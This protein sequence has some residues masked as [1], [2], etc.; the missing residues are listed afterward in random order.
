M[1]RDTKDLLRTQLT[2]Q[3][4]QIEGLTQLISDFEERFNCLSSENLV[5][6]TELDRVS[7]KNQSLV[8]GF[9]RVMGD[10]S[11]DYSEMTVDFDVPSAA[12]FS[13]D[14]A[15]ESADSARYES[16]LQAKDTNAPTRQG[17]MPG[18]AEGL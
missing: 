15:A 12:F 11:R 3:F 1:L 2:D 9:E 7:A 10:T 13:P 16:P 6:K 8:E 14:W 17:L 4:T 5:L 18:F